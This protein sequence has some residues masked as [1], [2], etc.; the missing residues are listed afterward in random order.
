MTHY[1]ICPGRV[2]NFIAI[3][4]QRV[5]SH[6][7][8]CH[9]LSRQCCTKDMLFTVITNDYWT[10]CPCYGSFPRVVHSIQRIFLSTGPV[11]RKMPTTE[12]HESNYQQIQAVPLAECTYFDR[13]I[14]LLNGSSLHLCSDGSHFARAVSRSVTSSAPT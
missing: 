1:I 6:Y 8:V 4:M 14:S 7:L 2:G 10:S 11:F 13:F 9:H 5:L 12:C 3:L